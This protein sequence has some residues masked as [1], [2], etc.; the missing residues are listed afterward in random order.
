[1]QL[2]EV[3]EK[4]DLTL[5]TPELE[6][7]A[8]TDEVKG[9]F[10]SDLLSNVM[11]KAQP[12]QVWVT[13]QGHRNVA[14]VASLI[15]LAAVIIAGGAQPAPDTLEKATS[16]VVVIFTTPLSAFDVVGRLYALGIRSGQ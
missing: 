16:N 1:M 7:D 15:G 6:G 10:V 11:G 4:L 2:Q 9:G 13:M 5:V 3:M 14:A 8:L 12:G